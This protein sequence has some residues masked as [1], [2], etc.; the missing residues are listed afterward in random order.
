MKGMNAFHRRVQKSHC[1]DQMG[2]FLVLHCKMYNILSPL[3]SFS[4]EVSGYQN[5]AVEKYFTMDFYTVCQMDMTA[6]SND[7]QL[8]DKERN[9]AK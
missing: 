7:V 2:A 4:I 6:N 1:R 3:V 5:E 9:V 8:F